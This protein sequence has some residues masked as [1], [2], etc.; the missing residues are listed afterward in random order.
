MHSC[1]PD[2]CQVDT[3]AIAECDDLV[4]GEDDLESVLQDV[5]LLQRA[6]VLGNDPEY[7][8]KLKVSNKKHWSLAKVI[9]YII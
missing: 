2:L 4:E 8:F 6:A 9:I 3:F 5:G 1:L 7:Q